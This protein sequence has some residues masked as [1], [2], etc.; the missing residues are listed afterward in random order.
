MSTIFVLFSKGPLAPITLYSLCSNSLL[1]LSFNERHT[2]KSYDYSF[3]TFVLHNFG[4]E[5]FVVL[6]FA[7]FRLWMEAVDFAV[8]SEIWYVCGQLGFDYSSSSIFFAQVWF[9]FVVL[10]LT[11]RKKKQ[12]QETKKDLNCFFPPTFFFSK[13]F[14]LNFS[15]D[16]WLILPFHIVRE[17]D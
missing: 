3:R 10:W 15:L 16:S 7:S 4:S 9:F 8:C 6:R 2:H 17:C 13:V 5:I 1:N 11:K 14:L 12:Q